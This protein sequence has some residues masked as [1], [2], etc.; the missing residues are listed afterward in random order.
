MDRYG[1]CPGLGHDGVP[2][3]GREGGA[4]E[5][6]HSFILKLVVAIWGLGACLAAAIVSGLAD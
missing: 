2:Q 4:R 1:S 6:V 5:G 3:M